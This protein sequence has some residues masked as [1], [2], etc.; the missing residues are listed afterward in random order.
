MLWANRP[1]SSIVLD[2]EGMTLLKDV[3]RLKPLQGI[4][5]DHQ[6]LQL[7]Y[8]VNHGGKQSVSK[9]DLRTLA[10]HI[11]HD[12]KDI[13]FFELTFPD[14]FFDLNP[15][16]SKDVN[17]LF[18][19]VSMAPELMKDLIDFNLHFGGSAETVLTK[20]K[21]SADCVGQGMESDPPL[22]VVKA[23]WQTFVN[24]KLELSS[25]DSVPKYFFENA[26]I[27]VFS[28]IN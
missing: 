26:G 19:E 28:Q 6:D 5:I 25:D 12:N 15:E 7:Q 1:D 3:L 21:S 13:F 27:P 9:E 2:H 11:R 24:G 20:V 14:I 8:S 22:E 17:I 23:S 4:R 10:Y 16:E 18:L